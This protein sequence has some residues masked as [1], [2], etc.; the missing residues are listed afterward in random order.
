MPAFPTGRRGTFARASALALAAVTAA[1]ALVAGPAA[2]PAEAAAVVPTDQTVTIA[3]SGYG[4][5]I[6]LSQWGAYGAA[7]SGL[8]HEKI[9]SF[10]YPGTTL[11]SLTS[12]SVIR[13]WITKDTDGSLEVAPASG[14]RLTNSARTDTWTPPTSSA[15]TA[16]RI[17]RSGS[18]R[19][20]EYRS[21]SSWVRRD[22]KI[23]GQWFWENTKSRYVTVRLPNK[24]SVD[25]RSRVTLAFVG[26]GARTVNALPFEDYL[27]SAIPAEMPASWPAAALRAQT[28]AARSYAAHAR[29][30]VASTAVH[31]ICDSTTCQV[32]A[33][34]ATRTSSGRRVNE[35]ASTD[36]AV[37]ATANRVL[38]NG[39]AY[40]QGMYSSSNGGYT[41]SGGISH[42]AAKS[43]P[44]DGKVSSRRWSV[45]LSQA[46]IQKA[47]PT[48]GT[49][50]SLSI[51][52]RDGRGAWGGRATSVSVSGSVRTVTVSGTTFRSLLGLRSSLLNATGGL[53]PGTAVY[54]RWQALGGVTGFVGAPTASEVVSSRGRSARFSGAD[55]YWS[56]ATGTHWLS[57]AVGKQ[58]WT[59]GASRSSLGFPTTDLVKTSSGT[60]ATFQHGTITCDADGT[61]VVRET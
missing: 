61:C 29:S 3:G 58:Y 5:G 9:L 37:K 6:G 49:F 13:V 16:W 46:Q 22:P 1:S 8:S 24:T 54:Q 42:L 17:R 60:K 12:G 26:T 39:T 51:V 21:G 59:L 41:V 4:H 43:D 48:I 2:T 19:V 38:K 35:Y 27:R 20:L 36:A 14:L 44:Y 18:S 11:G 52:Q 23:S 45:A 10:Y 7:A 30:R 53:K 47:F 25:F 50:R 34:L 15:I 28:V 55:L 32:Y 31:D 40:A 56:S 57:G 33:G